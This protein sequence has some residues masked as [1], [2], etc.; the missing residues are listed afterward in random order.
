M[1]KNVQKRWLMLLFMM[2]PCLSY[3][4]QMDSQVTGSVTSLDGEE[5]AGVTIAIQETGSEKKAFSMTDEKGLFK[6]DNLQQGKSYSLLFSFVGFESQVLKDFQIKQKDNNSIA[7]RMAE[8]ANALDQLVVI[9]Y[10]SQQK[11]FVTG[12]V[13][14]ISNEKLSTYSGSNFAQQL[15]GKAAGIVVND[16]NGQPGSNPQIVIRGI[17]TL[18]AGRNP[19]IVVDG[20]PL[21]EGTSLNYI[22]PN[23]IENL[24]V[25][26]DPASAAIYGSRA[27]NGVILITTKKS[28]SEKV[29]VALDVYTGFQQKA[30]K[31]EYVDAYDAATY[32][33][34]ARDWG[35]VSKN[36]ANRSVSDDRATRIA[37]GASLRE[38][39]LN[40]LAPYLAKEQGLVNTNWMDEIF[41][42][43]PMS[44]YNVAVSGSSA[45]TSYYTSFNHFS[46]EG[47]LINNNLKRYSAT[48]KLDSDIS[49]RAT[50]GISLN[51]SYT[52]QKFINT[53]GGFDEPIGMVTAMYPFFKPYNEDGSLAISE[54]IVANGP[55]DGA[56][57]ENPVAAAKL[58]KNNRSFFR[59]F[60]NAFV[61]YEIASGLKYK[62]VL[63]GDFA[64]SNFDFYNPSNLGAY[65]TPAPKPASA[66]ETNAS[67]NNILVEHTLN[68]S[69]KIGQH[70]FSVLAGYSFQREN[71]KS[72]LVTGTN[73]ADD[74][75]DNIAGASAF[76]VEPSRERWVQVSY[77]SRIQYIFNERYIASATYRTDGSSRFGVNNKWGK[78]PSVTAGWIWSKEGF[79]PQQ[80]LIT[81][82]KARATWGVSGNNQIGPYG[83]LALISGGNAANNYLFGSTLAP[84]FSAAATPNPN[85]SWETNTSYNLGLDVQLLNKIDLTAEYYN[86]TTSDLLLDVPIPQ[87]SGF[88]TSLQ[89]IGKIR[90]TGL[91]ISASAGGINLGKIGWSIDGNISFNKNKVL[92]LAPGQT[93]IIAGSNSNIITKVGESVAELY[94][95][96]VTGI[97]KTQEQLG[98]IPKLPG[99]LL[100]DYMVKDENGDGVIDSRDWISMGTYLP[101]FTYGI[102]NAFT[103][104][105]FQLSLSIAGVEG[106][107]VMES[108]FASR[109]ESGEGF[110]MPTKYYF[111]NRYHPEHNPDGFLGQP[112][113][114]NFSAARRS[115]RASDRFIYDADFIRLRDAQL[116]YNLPEALIKK[117]SIAAA[118]VYVSGNN[119]LTLTK[120]RGYNPEAT[121]PSVLTSG[122][123]TSNYPIAR[124]FLIGFN[125]T[126]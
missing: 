97:F 78:F 100:G 75:V 1:M 79:F 119:L 19:L 45:N 36:P 89:N 102:S 83:S 55:E 49:K 92:A 42:T 35:Y 18:T 117:A 103:F 111:E 20:F 47:I 16:A 125:L 61:S 96:Q 46:Q 91:E 73:I 15:S 124:T 33:T 63:G 76:T 26:K 30:D 105:N 40:Y 31:V 44:N 54:Q 8:A 109:E 115:V 87:Q 12:S 84:G 107:K 57:V 123:S 38:L 88:N 14:K 28:K 66:S 50:I 113:Y 39:P 23:D 56:L 110:A 67:L 6:I 3:A 7:I 27:A 21:T 59:M 10:G 9:G 98:T 5:L 24:E 65:R 32:L 34:E 112:N 101:K 43:A 37:K 4:Q 13:A 53:N 85:L 116:S 80:S 74:N 64:Q 58:I 108:N 48:L 122:Q 41:R 29:N 118:R 11:R 120:F 2:V 95:Y 77:L 99:T 86:A 106:R 72:T 114:G 25:L 22:N 69:K 71:S 52:T 93:Q 104:R 70:D 17:G 90:N 94:G 62:F 81:F 60:G 68:Y 121:T 51:P 126:F 82:G